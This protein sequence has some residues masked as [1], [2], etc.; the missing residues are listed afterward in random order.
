MKNH[1]PNPGKYTQGFYTPINPSKYK[2]KMPIRCLSSW[3]M[4][5]CKMFDTNPAI[6]YWSSE[7]IAI[8]Y[9]NPIKSALN[10]RRVVSKYY[11]DFLV[12]YVDK[13]GK[14]HTEIVEVKPFNQ[15]LMEAARGKKQKL[16]VL[17]NHAK[18]AAARA[19]AKRSG[20]SFRIITERDIFSGKR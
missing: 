18:W 12:V 3:E 13:F 15:T 8:E 9:V 6:L 2:G 16:D 1:L 17:L 4:K 5:V 11:P 10:N 7:S 14:Q 20:I 19:F